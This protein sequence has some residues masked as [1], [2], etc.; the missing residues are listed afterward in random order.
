[1]RTKRFHFLVFF[2]CLAITGCVGFGSKVGDSDAGV[3]ITSSHP[4]IAIDGEPLAPAFEYWTS[5][6]SHVITVVY[7]TLSYQYICVF[8]LDAQASA[9]YEIVH[10]EKME[11][12][13]LYRWWRR[14]I[15]FAERLDPMLPECYKADS[16]DQ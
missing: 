3:R 14:S 8:T 10:Q 6:G 13:V 5:V 9:R 4:I 11:P 1:M 12:L 7:P 16:G 2:L 15:L